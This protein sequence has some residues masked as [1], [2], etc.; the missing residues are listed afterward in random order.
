[1][2]IKA[3]FRL[4]CLAASLGAAGLHAQVPGA[5]APADWSLAGVLRAARQNADVRQA[6]QSLAAARADVLAVDHAPVPV[7]SGGV[8][9]IDLQNGVGAGSLL[10]Q[11]RL[12]KSLGLDWTI[13]RGDKRRLRTDAAGRLA[14]AVSGEVNETR[15]QQAIAAWTAWYDMLAARERLEHANALASSAQDMAR[16]AR[17][18]QK[19]GDLAEQDAA[20]SEIEAHRALGERGLA[21]LDQQRAWLTLQQLTGQRAPDAG[22]AQKIQEN[23]P[24]RQYGKQKLAINLEATDL[25]NRL[26]GKFDNWVEARADVGAARTRLDAARAAYDGARALQRADITV[27]ASVNHFPGTS[28]RMI[29]VRAQMPL[30]GVFGS[31]NYE[32]EIA[33]AQAAVLQAEAALEKIRLAA[34]IDLLRLQHELQMAAE[35]VQLYESDVVPQ[36]R[37]VADMAEQAYRK[38]ALSLTDLLDARRT[39]RATL[40]DSTGVRADHAR[41]L[42][43]WT[44][45]TAATAVEGAQP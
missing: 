1:M 28:N 11:K 22:T 32:G 12:D 20:R 24:F 31:Y 40:L 2:S 10:T 38:G 41:A 37:K 21:E 27:G 5:A 13:E 16:S 9:S 3:L 26:D 15:L 18:R 30:Q 45:R 4:V 19:A 8:A 35:R 14:Q 29:G 44:L 7:L 34:R 42:G 17:V 25:N 36:A 23:W 43:A 33:R 6:E 39:L